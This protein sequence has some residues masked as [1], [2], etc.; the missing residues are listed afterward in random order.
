MSKEKQGKAI[1]AVVNRTEV[2]LKSRLPPKKTPIEVRK[3]AAK[4]KLNFSSEMVTDS[5]S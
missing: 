1:N 4:R 3:R 5:T 2:S